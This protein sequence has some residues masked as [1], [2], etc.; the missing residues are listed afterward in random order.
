MLYTTSFLHAFENKKLHKM[1]PFPLM[2]KIILIISIITKIVI[3][4]TT[5]SGHL[6]KYREANPISSPMH[7][8]IY[9]IKCTPLHIYI[10]DIPKYWRSGYSYLQPS[11]TKILGGSAPPRPRLVQF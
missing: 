3:I 11:T 6:V 9:I 8:I 10:L 2:W 1:H 4:Y 5:K 7:D